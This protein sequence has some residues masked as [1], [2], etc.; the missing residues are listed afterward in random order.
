MQGVFCTDVCTGSPSSTPELN[1]PCVVDRISTLC[2]WV[3]YKTKRFMFQRPLFPNTI[4]Y[5]ISHNSC[6][7]RMKFINCL[8]DISI[9]Q[10][11]EISIS[12]LCMVF[13][14]ES[15]QLVCLVIYYLN[16]WCVVWGI[17]FQKN[18][19]Y[20]SVYHCNTI[21]YQLLDIWKMHNPTS[22]APANPDNPLDVQ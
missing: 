19:Y 21:L 10:S 1:A 11:L 5:K 16:N 17:S 13:W 14:D 15:L 2:L 20:L 22:A 18:D 6:V 12:F 4:Q 3:I 7:S 8:R 9:L